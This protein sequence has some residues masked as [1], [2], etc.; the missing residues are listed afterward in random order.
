VLSAALDSGVAVSSVLIFFIIVYPKN[1]SIG[2]HSVLAWWGNSGYTH[3][4]DYNHVAKLVPD[5]AVGYFG[6]GPGH[7]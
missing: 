3:T 5:P 6:P 1:G 7:F 4:L 2:A